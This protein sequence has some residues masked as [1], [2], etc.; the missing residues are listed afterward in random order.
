M[1]LYD[2]T[3]LILKAMT[4]FNLMVKALKKKHPH[5]SK[6]LLAIMVNDELMNY[7]ERKAE[8]FRLLSGIS[9]N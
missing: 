6:G 3:N 7:L 4:K 5:F 8:F 2:I 1:L 9:A